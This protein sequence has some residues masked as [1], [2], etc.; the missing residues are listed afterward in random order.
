MGQKVNAN[1]FRIGLTHSWPSKWY[2]RGKKFCDLFLQDIT[3]KRYIEKKMPDAGISLIEFDRGK[4]TS[5]IIHSSKP[6]VIIGKQGAAIEDLRKELE[7][8]FGG[9]F[10]VTIQE[11]R[12]PDANAA[13]IA[14][15]IQGQIVRRMPYRRAVKMSIEKALQAGAIGVKVVISGRLNGAEIARSELFKEG[16]IPLQ[17]LRANVEFSTKHAV[18]T[19]GTIGVQVWVYHGLVFKKVQQIH[20][21]SLHSAQTQPQP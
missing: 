21:A 4:K 18:T 1:G 14:E 11:I 5:V 7:K 19:Y 15:T 17:T 6:G 12:N 16:N 20:S 8:K 13:V 9:S 10:E 3:I 2:A